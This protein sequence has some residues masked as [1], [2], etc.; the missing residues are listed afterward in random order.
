MYS[1]ISLL[2]TKKEITSVLESRKVVHS[3]IPLF[4]RKLKMVLI[5]RRL[6]YVALAKELVLPFILSITVKFLLEVWSASVVACPMINHLL[7]MNLVLTPTVCT[8]YS[9]FVILVVYSMELLINMFLLN[10]WK[11]PVKL[12][13]PRA[14]R[15]FNSIHILVWSIKLPEEC[16]IWLEKK[17]FVD[18]WFYVFVDYFH[19]SLWC[20]QDLSIKI[21][22][23]LVD[24]FY[25]LDS[26]EQLP[27][28][29]KGYQSGTLY[30]LYNIC[31]NKM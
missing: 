25:L 18:L 19:N 30:V 31:S 8:Y 9:I 2:G 1:L 22:I 14:W 5:P 24:L 7:L 21:S 10:S 3:S 4:R 23:Y 28:L 16:W 17:W 20:C 12:F 15:M 26:L 13:V 29:Q 6:L 27:F 11:M